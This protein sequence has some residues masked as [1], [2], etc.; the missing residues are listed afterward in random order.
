VAGIGAN[1]TGQ[2]VNNL[3]NPLAGTGNLMNNLGNKLSKLPMLSK[4]LGS[5]VVNDAKNTFT[6]AKQLKEA[7]TNPGISFSIP[8]PKGNSF[9]I[10]D[11]LQEGAKTL[12]NALENRIALLK[13]DEGKRRLVQQEYEYLKS[14][15]FNETGINRQ[16]EINAANR[17]SELEHTRVFGN[18]NNNVIEGVE[19][20]SLS[21]D[22]G[23]QDAATS[24]LRY[25]LVENGIPGNNAHFSQSTIIPNED[26]FYDDDTVRRA[27][28]LN[29]KYGRDPELTNIFSKI[30]KHKYVGGYEAPGE[31]ALGIGF[32]KSKAIAD[33]EIQH[34]LQRSRKLA[35]DTELKSLK[36]KDFSELK[37]KDFGALNYFTNGSRGKESSAFLAEA[38]TAMKE[39]G[40]IKHD[41]DEMTPELI[42]ETFKYFQKNPRKIFIKEPKQIPFQELSQT[43]IFDIHAPTESNFKLLSDSFN[44]LPVLVPAIG[45]TYMASQQNSSFKNGGVIKDDMGYWNPDNVG[46]TVEIGSGNITMEGV[47][48]P[49]L[50]ISKQTGEEKIMFPGKNYSFSKTKQVIE[51]PLIKWLDKY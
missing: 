9:K 3:T 25:N 16:A 29:K 11:S 6:Y 46:K 47:N 22:I 7:Y 42:Q 27:L 23:A 12:D 1:S 8:N 39:A 45:A 28:E 50:G 38:R 18:T 49:L 41:Y 36:P 33:H 2:F 51:Y 26:I 35:I 5:M 4:E 15:G 37:D 40:L 30:A 19:R 44:K 17:I 20:N 13:T 43:R 10:F 21:K 31:L 14:I 24:L 34:G 32:P 48:Q